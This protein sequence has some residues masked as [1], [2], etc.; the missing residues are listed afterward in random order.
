[1]SGDTGSPVARAVD[2][3]KT[4]GSGPAV[5]T[6]LAGV[7]LEFARGAFTAVMGPSGSGKSTLLHCL[8]GLDNPTSGQVWV[9]ERALVGLDDKGLTELRRSSVGF[10]F[11]QFNL[12]PTLTAG[13][14]IRLS[15]DI[16]GRTIDP[17]WFDEVI[18]AVGL[19]QRLSHRPSELSGGEQQRVACARAILGRP[20]VI[21]ADEPTGNLDSR[22]SADILTFLRA[23]VDRLGQ[24]LVMV[25]HDPAAASRSDRVVF[26]SDGQVVDDLPGPSV[27]KILER[28]RHID[29]V[30]RE[31]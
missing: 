18:D 15:M 19:G 29:P 11:Q 5:V 3:V 13:E 28:V 27:E 17:T 30:T 9:G 16:A 1:M 10:V 26:L 7:T 21:F 25:T 2:L 14:N 24:S 22:T 4:Y 20:E 8:A 23:S 6:A 31:A 12:L